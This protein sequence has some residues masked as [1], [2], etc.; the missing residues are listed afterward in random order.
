VS[1]DDVIDDESTTKIFFRPGAEPHTPSCSRGATRE[2]V[3]EKE[4]QRAPSD[5][6]AMLTVQEAAAFLR[7]D[8]KTIHRE[9]AAGR[10]P[11]I[12]LG[13][14][15]RIAREVLVLRSKSA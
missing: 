12:R 4:P 10:L 1:R 5:A 15:I 3:S 8:R 7:V 2:H 6:A 11:H 14:V 13:R 9:I